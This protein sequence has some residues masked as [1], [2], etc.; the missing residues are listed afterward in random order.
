MLALIVASGRGRAQS[1]RVPADSAGEVA[2]ADAAPRHVSGRIVRPSGRD[3]VPVAGVWATIHRV[4]RDSAGPLDSVRTS[5]DGRYAFRYRPFGS[6]DAIYFVSA[7]YDGIAY[8]TP[9]LSSPRATGEAAEITV[10]DTTSGPLPI[11]V[12][13]HHVIVGAP[14]VDGRREVLEVYELANDS[15]LT[16][17]GAGGQGA[18]FVAGAPRGA[19]DFRMG[20][21]DVTAEAAALDSGR[22]RIFAPFAPGLKQVSFSY[23]LPSKAFPLRLPIERTTD[24]LEALVEDPAGK[25]TG[26]TLAEVAPVTLEGRSFRR[27]QAS[28]V[29]SGAA[30][31]VDL[32]RAAAR[33]RGAFLM[34]LALSI[35]AAMLIALARAFRRRDAPL[36]VGIARDPAR[37]TPERLARVIADLDEAFERRVAPT[38]AQRT[39]YAE[40]RAE[41]KARLVA[42]LA[43]D[44]SRA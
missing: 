32:P 19:A 39:E 25:A 28:D 13:G 14:R 29:P 16:L 6:D 8:F 4:G 24:V 17:V 37:D 7:I 31:V 27:F 22:V 41:L 38:E 26:A 44:G 9:P 5:R 43:S 34:A 33:T 30:M 3:L 20:T 23:T 12:R 18:T 10:F 1:S 21:G 36:P 11:H 42:A 15:S 40:M 2:G 35:G